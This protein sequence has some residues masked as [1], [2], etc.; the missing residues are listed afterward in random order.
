MPEIEGPTDL[1][2]QESDAY[3]GRTMDLDG[4]GGVAT[5]VRAETHRFGAVFPSWVQDHQVE[6][7]GW[8]SLLNLLNTFLMVP[9]P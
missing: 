5:L 4:V 3:I 7:E 9:I 8:S 6:T 2:D 1:Y